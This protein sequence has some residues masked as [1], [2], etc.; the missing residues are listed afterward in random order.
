[1]IKQAIIMIC[2]SLPDLCA[3]HSILLKHR[4]PQ[5]KTAQ[6]HKP[7]KLILPCTE[8]IAQQSGVE[9]PAQDIQKSKS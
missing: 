3:Q 7:K 4:F 9:L 2:I 1:M 6:S 8:C 5:H